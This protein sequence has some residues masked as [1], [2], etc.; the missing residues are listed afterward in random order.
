MARRRAPA[1][2]AWTSGAVVA[3]LLVGGAVLAQGYDA[4]DVPTVESSVWV[5]RD[6]AGGQFARVNT[7][8]GE[9]ET[10]NDAAGIAD[11]VQ[12]RSS[13]FVVGA[14]YSKVWPID[15]AK[16]LDVD[17]AGVADDSDEGVAAP[18]G[19]SGIETA[20]RYVLFSGPA[21]A[22]AIG[23][24]LSAADR[25]PTPL[26]PPRTDGA[27]GYA[28]AASTISAAGRVALYSAQEA[29]RRIRVFDI[30]TALWRT[31]ELTDAPTGPGGLQL[32]FVGDRVVLLQADADAPRLWV[33][34]AGPYALPA[35][36]GADA[37]LQASGPASDAVL[38]ASS[39][40][41][42]RFALAG[43]AQ[44]E[45][46]AAAGVA[47]RPVAF[48]DRWAA[49]WLS[50]GTGSLW[51]SGLAEPIPLE[52]DG[53][54]FD[55][56]VRI[57]PA[58][59]SNG[60]RAVLLERS[61][62]MLWSVPDGALIPLR[63]WTADEVVPAPADDD[64]P[65]ESPAPPVA[66]DDAFGVRPGATVVLPVLY[67]DH[68]PNPEDVL[69]IDPASVEGLDPA[70]GSLSLVGANQTLVLTVTGDAPT[71]SFRY[72]ATDGKNAS[73]EPATVRL[74][75]RTTE[76]TAPAW[77]A[78]YFAPDPC[79]VDWPSPQILV[80]GTATFDVLRGWVD[81]EGD[82]MVID[83]AIPQDG[84]PLVAMPTADG[85]LAIGDTGRAPGSYSILVTVR[86][87]SGDVSQPRELTVQVLAA[88]DFAVRGGAV[89]GRA[90][91]WTTVPAARFASGGSGGYH[92]LDVTEL[93]VGSRLDAD[94]N[95]AEGT[96]R[97]RA[98]EPGEHI[99]SVRVKDA[100]TP[101][102]HDVNVR[103][104]VLPA[105]QDAVAVP[106]L[107]AYLRQGED[108]LIDV[109]GAVQNTTGRV[110]LVTSATPGPAPNGGP[111]V[112][113]ASVVDHSLIRLRGLDD[114]IADRLG[115]T[116]GPFGS[117]AFTL[118]D[119]DG[120]SVR[121]TV[122]VF[123]VPPSGQPPIAVPD[124]ATVRA[125]DVADI[126]VLANDVAPRGER[127]VL[128]PDV[129]TSGEGAGLAFSAG[130][131]LRYVAPDVPGTY[132]VFYYAYLEGAPELLA[133]SQ[134]TVTVLPSG[135][136][137]APRP[138]DL[139]ARTL[140]GRTVSIPVPIGTM[141]PDGDRVVVTGVSQPAEPR[142]G[143][144]MVGEGGASL[145][146]TAPEVNQQAIGGLSA[147]GW[148][149][150]FGYTVR[151]AEGATGTA[152][153]RVAVSA[154]DPDGLAP[155]TF[156][157]K[158]R[159]RQVE[160]GGAPVPIDVE[161][162]L[163]D[164]DPAAGALSLVDPTGSGLH[165]LYE[166]L[167]SMP[168]RSA[169]GAVAAGSPYEQAR[170]L[171]VEPRPTTLADGSTE[172][173]PD[174]SV[175]F[176]VTDA[177][178]PG[179]YYF[180]YTAE[181]LKTRSTAEGVI[182]ITVSP[183]DSPNQPVIEDTVVTAQTRGQVEA[184]GI[185]VLSG[186]VV[187]PTGDATALRIAELGAGAPAGFAFDGAR[188]R[189][190]IPAAGATIP[191]RVEYGVDPAS[192]AARSAWGL[193]RIPALDDLRLQ[194]VRLPDPVTE[195]ET[196]EIDL[197]GVLGIGAGDVLELSPASSFA[198][199]RA[200]V[201][202]SLAVTRC[203]QRSG[204]GAVLEYTAGYS[205]G[206]GSDT[207]T[208][209]VRLAGQGDDAWSTVVVPIP[210]R[211]KD[212]LA[213]L[214]PV[215]KTVNILNGRITVDLHDELVSWAGG[216][217]MDDA[218]RRDTMTFTATYGG[219]SFT[220]TPSGPPSDLTLT[221]DVSPTAPSG[222]RETVA[223]HLDYPWPSD[224]SLP[225][226]QKD[227]ALVL[228]VG[229][230]PA[231]G[232]S[233]AT[234][235]QA[236][237]A[238]TP[239][240]C[241]LD[242]VFPSDRSGQFNPLS[243]NTSGAS[244]ALRLVGVGGSGAFDCPALGQA[245]AQGDGIRLTLLAAEENRPAG[246]TCVVPFTVADV[247]GRTGTGQVTFDVTGFPQKPETPVLAYSGAGTVQVDVAL[248]AATRAYPAV[249]AVNLYE[250]G[251]PVP[252]SSCA[253]LDAGTFRCTVTGLANAVHHLYAAR[254]ANARGDESALSGTLE[255]WAFV[256]PGFPAGG[257]PT[258]EDRVYDAGTTSPSRGRLRIEAVCLEHNSAVA[259]ET[260]TVR[261]AISLPGNPVITV[262]VDG[263]TG[264]TAAQTVTVN[265]TGPYTVTA[266][267]IS[268]ATPPPIG[269]G[270]ASAEGSGTVSPALVSH[271]S[272][273]PAPS[274]AV[275]WNG[276]G[277][278]TATF[279][280][281]WNG[282]DLGT[283]PPVGSFPQ[284]AFLAW[285]AGDPEPICSAAPNAGGFTELAVSGA[286]VQRSGT[287]GATFSVGGAGAD[288]LVNNRYAFKAC[289][290]HGYGL[291]QSAVTPATTL[292]LFKKPAAPADSPMTY[293]PAAADMA[294]V[295]S[296][297]G[298]ATAPVL[299]WD[300]SAAT[301]A[302]TSAPAFVPPAE[303]VPPGSSWELRYASG[304]SPS[305]PLPSGSPTAIRSLVSG[306]Q[307]VT[308][309]AQWC[310]TASGTDFCSD[311]SAAIAPTKQYTG[312]PFGSSASLA[313]PTQSQCLAFFSDV[314]DHV[315]PSAGA[316]RYAQWWGIPDG[317]RPSGYHAGSVL[318][319]A[320]LGGYGGHPGYTATYDGVYPANRAGHIE[321]EYQAN[322][323]FTPA[324]DPAGPKGTVTNPAWQ[325]RFEELQSQ[326]AAA[327][328]IPEPPAGPA[329]DAWAVARDLWAEDQTNTWGHD[330]AAVAPGDAAA[331]AEAAAA[332]APEG[333][334]ARDAAAADE[335][336]L[337]AQPGGGD[338]LAAAAMDAAAAAFQSAAL[339][340]TVVNP[341]T[342][343]VAGQSPFA[344]L[345]ST[346]LVYDAGTHRFTGV[347][348][349]FGGASA[350]ST[351]RFDYVVAAL[352]A[353]YPGGY[354]CG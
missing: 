335:A 211:P 249:T 180:R 301:D 31:I 228:Y 353:H 268:G 255:T 52:I 160:P 94:W 32:A 10:V 191:F 205:P 85:R 193:L 108:A 131:T 72:R 36:I 196:G 354:S 319:V 244:T 279:A 220:V 102:Q 234:L 282:G 41:L 240:A 170:A 204:G 290:S 88:P 216:F 237:D 25:A 92:V 269:T 332:A 165:I 262:P 17:E 45:Q 294:S 173:Y 46:V 325:T 183:G 107:T 4:E 21:P 264:C 162:L 145:L 292:W 34:G 68:D 95:E 197:A 14:S 312:I 171:Q 306:N 254:T 149:A 203:A 187:W 109:L 345:P 152:T 19:T 112:L 132:T 129:S 53:G 113:A 138:A 266:T 89:L 81:A 327:T 276:T 318:D 313:L 39:N 22:V 75:L 339:P 83:A 299:T 333:V 304:T 176:R 235:T 166:V 297:T 38:V 348:Y 289:G 315:I 190:R 135:A 147:G 329:H 76:R 213:I 321:S 66:V 184:G 181:S 350:P 50:G 117:V 261:Y 328:G 337:R 233:G 207:C 223:I 239:D 241:R 84:A 157:D 189:G 118:A 195:L 243:G 9:I 340:A 140:A 214:T 258:Y 48:G 105:E 104:T 222:A 23:A 122:S 18:E 253:R 232:P 326:Y 136:N 194:V 86:D 144:V 44:L 293:A 130:S 61:T 311:A 305:G 28:A 103:Y 248:G 60:D 226:F 287:V 218:G 177:T 263:A 26:E 3:T 100:A 202:E 120:N 349:A 230:V 2:I 273:G 252:S 324:S 80:G 115:R 303:A 188:I 40:G 201:N 286:A 215:T 134:V 275:S 16:P 33:D 62:G 74:A 338:E 125:G 227:V 267:P 210:I 310:F 174:G 93:T 56:N 208:V 111:T 271:G 164:R 158:I 238:R 116:D 283:P 347:V 302:P 251:A 242:V 59:V 344:I 101:N 54:A 219:G 330:T 96:I 128:H 123:L 57:R 64:V 198:T 90:G 82:A 24:E 6:A 351:P 288:L 331:R 127:L 175:R 142:L 55:D 178:A 49:A 47:A 247:R 172:L 13:A 296:F 278:V 199:H 185:D 209:D 250:V 67:N 98:A 217:S 63:Q 163:N 265:G 256:A 280:A 124:A 320:Y 69:A 274:L 119:S 259:G 346:T 51:V 229:Q 300:L 260:S 15:A 137:R 295:Y 169:D 106:P 212:P 285:P 148:Q 155:I 179:T 334:A 284:I 91:E 246:G 12:A 126:A 224:P 341:A 167:P 309:Y 143:A 257:A 186:K 114:A 342:W 133:R 231:Q 77:C 225:H 323:R 277:S 27:A 308:W 58:L 30:T 87:A 343:T 291:A 151:D 352:Q 79:F 200:S 5:A 121:G 281:N 35:G 11:V 156:I 1:I 99:V 270:T 73:V 141:D 316:A 221:I 71:A 317:T 314:N 298:T 37:L 272:P 110:L 322:W 78:D 153:V 206:I 159:V 192:G 43:G 29:E 336:V 168:G 182:A 42:H 8:I 245:T 150:E 65:D 146:F 307:F 7:D 154:Q 97:L 161:P 20:G 236:C 139:E 70:F